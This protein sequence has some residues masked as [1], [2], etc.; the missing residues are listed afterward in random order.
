MSALV[1]QILKN[2]GYATVALRERFLRPDYDQHV[3]DPLQLPDMDTAV[4]RIVRAV[5]TGEKIAIYGDYDID[6]LSATA[7]LLDGLAAIGADVEAYIPDRFEEGYG[8][9]TEALQRLHENGTGLVITVDCGSVSHQPIS[10]AAGAGLDVIVTDHHET[11]PPGSPLPP[12]TAVINPKRS[13]SEYPFRDLAGVGVAFKLMQAI[14]SLTSLLPAGREKWLLDLVALGTVCDVVDLVDENR[15]LVSYGLRVFRQ[16]PRSG[17]QALARVAGTEPADVDTYHFGFVLGPR[18]NAAGRLEHA[19][20]ALEVLT[21]SDT[22]TASTAAAY[23]DDLNAERRTQQDKILSMAIEQAEQYRDD[24]VLVLS[25]PEWSHGI[26]GIV[27]AKIMERYS[28]PTIILQEDGNLA[29]GSARSLGAFNMVSALREADEVL[30]KYGG[31]HVAAG[32][33]LRP[34]G[35]AKLRDTLNQYYRSQRF[36]SLAARPAIDMEM[37]HL[38]AVNADS[39]RELQQLAPFGKGNP[40]P[41]FYASGLQVKTGYPVGDKQEHL[42]LVLSDGTVDHDAIAFGMGDRRSRLGDTVDA[43]FELDMNTYR[44]R[45]KPQ[46]RIKELS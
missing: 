39:Y 28:K 4:R 17:L 11:G 9:N 16:T 32:C 37:P 25:H 41:V 36:G 14:Q 20:R 46:L 5:E 27:A 22:R 19:R 15:V 6:G 21:T 7:L 2:R 23:L 34:S 35:I 8:I 24:P 38:A 10:W 45:T 40:R 44:G 18:L 29:K 1:E 33:T 26:V 13:D 30:E 43:W 3:H 31:H 12:A 42:K